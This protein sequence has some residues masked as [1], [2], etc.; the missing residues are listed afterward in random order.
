MSDDD[1]D[2][3]SDEV[4]AP[5]E[6]DNL[7]PD[8]MIDTNEDFKAPSLTRQKSYQVY[9]MDEILTESR[10]LIRETMDV[11]GIP[12]QAAAILLLR[13]FG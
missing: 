13:S 1:L 12:S 4:E 3:V 7:D 6:D 2:Y 11:L 10:K 9:E 8:E 5:L